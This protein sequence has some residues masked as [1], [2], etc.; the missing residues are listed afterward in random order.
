VVPGD[1]A[2]GLI[3]APIHVIIVDVH[4]AH[5]FTLIASGGLHS[6]VKTQS[7]SSHTLLTSFTDPPPTQAPPSLLLLLSDIAM[8][9]GSH[10]TPLQKRSRSQKVAQARCSE[11]HNKLKQLGFGGHKSICSAFSSSS[12]SIRLQFCLFPA[13]S[14]SLCPSRDG[15]STCACERRWKWTMVMLLR[16]EAPMQITSPNNPTGRGNDESAR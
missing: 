9:H 1:F 16:C 2:K 12:K 5:S 10:T 8:P 11:L 13:C 14:P 6:C 4:R 3:D 7:P 15:K